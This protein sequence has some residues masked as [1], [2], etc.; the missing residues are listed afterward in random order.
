MKI[1]YLPRPIDDTRYTKNAPYLPL[2][3]CL[4]A[5]VELNDGGVVGPFEGGR[6]ASDWMMEKKTYWGRC[7]EMPFKERFA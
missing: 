1:V 5:F 3:I 7:H 4:K 6:E 2:D